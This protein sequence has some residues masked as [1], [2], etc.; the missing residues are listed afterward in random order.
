MTEKEEIAKKVWEVINRWDNE[1]YMP[2]DFMEDIAE[3]LPRPKIKVKKTEKRWLVSA[4]DEENQR[5]ATV[6]L[7]R[8]KAEA[9][10]HGK[11]GVHAV[12]EIITTVEVE[13]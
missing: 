12:Q 8:K 2:S 9:M 7:F 13:E 11:S 4:W 5:I 10:E 6:G 1:D 3:I